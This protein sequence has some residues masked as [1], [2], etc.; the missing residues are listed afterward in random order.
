VDRWLEPDRVR[1]FTR[2]KR[3]PPADC[4]SCGLADRCNNRCACVNLRGTDSA[5][6]PSGTLCALERILLSAVDE[7]AARL[8]EKKVSEFIL[9]NY[10]CSYH[11][12]Y[13]IEKI[14]EERAGTSC[15]KED[16]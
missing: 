4:R 15:M 9:R 5:A 12:L 1:L 7:T 2:E 10:S 11:L 14:L 13:S 6:V 16:R 3:I 8:F